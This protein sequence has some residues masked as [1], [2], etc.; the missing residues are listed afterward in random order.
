MI[1]IFT[2]LMPI[3]L[4]IALGIGLRRWLA[5]DVTFWRTVERITYF[6]LFPSLLVTP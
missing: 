6:V 5:P 1:A 4:V 2:A 3:F